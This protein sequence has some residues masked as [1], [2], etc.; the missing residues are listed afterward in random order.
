ML[1]VVLRTQVLALQYMVFL[2]LQSNWTC[3]RFVALSQELHQF[4]AHGHRSCTDICSRMVPEGMSADPGQK[5]PGSE[6]CWDSHGWLLLRWCLWASPDSPE[7][8][9]TLLLSAMHRFQFHVAGFQ[10]HLSSNA[11]NPR[12][13]EEYQ[14]RAR[15]FLNTMF[16]VHPYSFQ[17]S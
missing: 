5:Q 7:P 17:I 2:T 15:L 4:D 16:Q 13:A 1:P 8:N 14:T 10:P 12:H 11:A 9:H 3:N 6:V